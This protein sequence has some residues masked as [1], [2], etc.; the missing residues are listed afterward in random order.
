MRFTKFKTKA[1]FSLGIYLFLWRYQVATW[2]RDDFGSQ[3]DPGH[4]VI[5]MFIPIYGW[6]AW[7]R[8]FK[9]I[10]ATQQHSGMTTA[11]S[12][13]RAFW[14]SSMWFNAGPYSNKH[15]NALDTFAKGRAS[16][17]R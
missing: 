4:E 17:T 5:S 6:I 10:S 14:W 12:P 16:A 3:I 1:F 15:L 13:G 9:T 2:L 11:M 7:W 8:F